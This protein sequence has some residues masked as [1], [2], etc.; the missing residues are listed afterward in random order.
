MLQH[1]TRNRHAFCWFLKGRKSFLGIFLRGWG[2]CCV[3]FGPVNLI[4][5]E[6]R[7]DSLPGEGNAM[8]GTVVS[9]VLSKDTQ[10]VWLSGQKQIYPL[11]WPDQLCSALRLYE[12][13]PACLILSSES[14]VHRPCVWVKGTQVQA[15]FLCFCL[16]LSSRVGTGLLCTGCLHRW[17]P[18]WVC[19][20][21]QH[22]C[23]LWVTLPTHR[24]A[25]RAREVPQ[26]SLSFP[27]PD[28][29]QTL[30]FWKTLAK[31]SVV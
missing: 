15:P 18:W 27:C 19:G 28:W 29:Q 11:Q 23:T 13:C 31:V 8:E 1:K 5:M 12:M 22:S 17:S 16:F 7:G 30:L 14:V 21:H 24:R 4:E 25:E 9:G 2:L 10:T 6:S 20:K 3:S 26:A